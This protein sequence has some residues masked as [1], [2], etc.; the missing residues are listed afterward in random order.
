M[1]ARQCVSGGMKSP[2]YNLLHVCNYRDHQQREK[3]INPQTFVGPCLK[4]SH[5]FPRPRA[6][7]LRGSVCEFGAH[8]PVSDVILNLSCLRSAKAMSFKPH[9]SPF[10]RI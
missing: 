5:A 4:W 6:S 10:L 8:L 3:N 7:G 9:G 2:I 1:A